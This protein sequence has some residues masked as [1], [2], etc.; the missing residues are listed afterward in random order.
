M[1]RSVGKAVGRDA[2]QLY[3][4]YF[5]LAATET[6]YGTTI[7]AIRHLGI[8]PADLAEAARAEIEALLE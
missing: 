7:R 6:N 5:V 8:D 2:S 3:S 4:T 1:F